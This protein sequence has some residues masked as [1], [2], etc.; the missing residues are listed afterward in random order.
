MG[1]FITTV[2]YILAV[3]P[4][5]RDPT[6]TVEEAALLRRAGARAVSLRVSG[7]RLSSVI[8]SHCSPRSRM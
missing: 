8:T 5:E 2:V 6:L 1:R 4:S 7:R 3:T